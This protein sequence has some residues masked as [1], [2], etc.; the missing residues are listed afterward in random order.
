VHLDGSV[1][2]QAIVLL[3]PARPHHNNLTIPARDLGLT[4]WDARHDSNAF[5]FT[6]PFALTATGN[7]VGFWRRERLGMELAPGAGEVS[8]A[9]L[10]DAWSPTYRPR[11][12]T[13]AVTAGAQQSRNG[14]GVLPDQVTVGWPKEWLL[15]AIE[16]RRPAEA[17]DQDL[18]GIAARY[19]TRTVDFVAMQLEYPWD[20]AAP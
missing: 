8:L 5:Q 20:G 15:P 17:L 2:A 13:F 7:T 12:M 1:S 18:L 4:Y 11:A 16:G 14:I 3:H 19:G 6:R 10:A 9:L